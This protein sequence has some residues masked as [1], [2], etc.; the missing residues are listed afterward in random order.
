MIK[1]PVNV[2]RTKYL[3]W[4][5][6]LVAKAKSRPLLDGYVERHHVVPVSLGGSNNTENIITLTAREHYI[7]H[8]L[9]WR[10]TL[11]KKS[12]N[13]MT[14]AL[15]VMVNGSGNKKQDRNY[16]IPS[17][18]YESA[19]RSFV[20]AM[21]AY[22]AEHG[23]TMKGKKHTP[24]AL[25]KMRAWQAVPE[26][27]QKQR[28]RI[29]GEKNHM[30]GKLH[31][32]E[33]KK[34]ISA[35]CAATW[36]EED[37]KAKSIWAKEKWQDPEYKK[38]MLDIRKTSE[39]WI[40]RD[41]KTINRKAADTKMARGW[42]PTEDTKKKQ[43]ETRK[44][45][46]ATGEI[47]PWNKG[48]KCNHLTGEN[49]SNF[50]TYQITDPNRNVFVIKTREKIVEFCKEQKIGYWS[51]IDLASGKQGKNRLHLEGWTATRSSTKG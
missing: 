35:A 49:S 34:Q 37:K 29:L 22:F 45:K 4:Y 10:M 26:I 6:Q 30:Y 51:L 42:K 32:D 19:R 38:T 40:N 17:R 13:K 2:T 7:A 1:W 39:A 28:D 14:M 20:Q 36:T 27:K 12:H 24:E 47:V 15:H 25:A 41:W 21:T 3:T 11:D 8:L 18:I 31:S 46:L 43:S 5:E 44:T 16:L 9:L 48:K 50:T 23:G 33:T